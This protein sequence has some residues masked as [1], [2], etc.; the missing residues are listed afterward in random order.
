MY[1]GFVAEQRKAIIEER[2]REKEE[3]RAKREAERLRE[4]ATENFYRDQVALLTEKLEEAKRNEKIA[5]KAHAEV[6]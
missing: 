5:A 4:E 6:C 2:R 1:N 3:K